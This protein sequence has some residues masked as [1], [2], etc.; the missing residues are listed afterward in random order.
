VHQTGWTGL[1]ADMIRRRHGAV[2]AVGD[3]VRDI[4]KEN[5]Q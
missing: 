4:Q 5:R 1:V 2:R 3:V